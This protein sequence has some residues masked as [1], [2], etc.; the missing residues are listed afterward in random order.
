MYGLSEKTVRRW[1]RSGRLRADKRDGAY[2]VALD[3]VS[4]L[5][6]Q[7]SAPASAPV[8]APGTDAAD[9]PVRPPDRPGAGSHAEPLLAIIR[10][11][12]GE[13]VQHAAAAAMW[14]ERAA[15]LAAELDQTRRML[16][17]PESHQTREASNLGAEA[18]E[19]TLGPSKPESASTP[20]PIEPGPDGSP[21]PWWRKWWA[22]LAST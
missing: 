10:E 21:P 12:R 19:P 14:Q 11:L 2:S 17:A 13:L 5:V 8:S 6:A 15:V 3:D 7:V 1:I 9:D 18:P 4:A 16:E 20:A 22:W